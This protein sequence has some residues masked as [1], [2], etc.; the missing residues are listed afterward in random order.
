MHIFKHTNFDFL[1]WRIHAIVLSWAIIVAGAFVFFTK[2]IPLGIEFAGGTS[3]IVQFEQPVSIQQVRDAIDKGFP[4]GGGEATINT[5]GDPAQRQVMIRVPTVG[6]A[7]G[8]SLSS[9]ADQVEKALKRS[10]LATFS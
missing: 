8:T 3:V 6:A 2:G 7:S 4:G 10:S 9:T 1:K 5:Y